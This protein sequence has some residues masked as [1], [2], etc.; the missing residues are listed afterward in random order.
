MWDSVSV[1]TIHNSQSTIH[2]HKYS[3]IKSVSME[4]NASVHHTLSKSFVDRHHPVLLRDF[5]YF[6]FLFYL[7]IPSQRKEMKNE[8]EGDG[9]LKVHIISRLF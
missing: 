5:Q 4:Q 1:A 3:E 6:T 8:K 9:G 7:H 2:N